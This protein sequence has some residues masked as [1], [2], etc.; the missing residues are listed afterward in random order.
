MKI[1]IQLFFLLFLVSCGNS[2]EYTYCD[3]GS[4]KTKSTSQKALTGESFIYYRSGQMKSH[5]IWRN[6][7]STGTIESYFENGQKSQISNW[8]DGLMDGE[9]VS[10][11]ESGRHKIKANYRL[12][13]LVGRYDVFYESGNRLELVLFDDNSR[14]YYISRWEKDG[15]RSLS[16]IL[17]LINLEL[18]PES[19]RASIRLPLKFYGRAFLSIGTKTEKGFVPILNN[20]ILKADTVL[21]FVYPGNLNDLYYH[22]DF[23]PA[24]LDTLDEIGVEKR[25]IQK[26][27]SVLK[28]MN[29]GIAGLN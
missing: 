18:S 8:K 17:P 16:M 12:G 6:G 2:F 22:F 7:V 19:I 28:K 27:D 25:V 26:P 9:V 29:L 20:R 21:S 4:V 13:V 10:F 11:Y 1:S 15:Q 23:E 24:Q 3:D 5:S 14:V